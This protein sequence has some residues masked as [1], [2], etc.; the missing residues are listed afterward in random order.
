MSRTRVPE[1]LC[2]VFPL[3]TTYSGLVA[4]NTVGQEN[5]TVGK[6]HVFTEPALHFLPD[7][8]YGD[9]VGW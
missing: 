6:M 4:F 3:T 7:L 5:T 2:S 9:G 1:V 8:P